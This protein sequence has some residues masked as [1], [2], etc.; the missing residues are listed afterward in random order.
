M[1]IAALV[2]GIIGLIISFI[3]LCGVIAFLPCLVGLAL[4]IADIAIKGKRG[5]PKTM[6]IVGTVLN[7]VALVI[8]IVWSVFIAAGTAE[9]ISDPAFQQ[10]VQKEIEDA[11]KKAQ[12]GQGE[13]VVETGKVQVK[14]TI[15]APP[16]TPQK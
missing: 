2:L 6:G 7:G 14:T 11:Q 13:I 16:K 4:G 1:G 5:Q 10:T 8:I 3:P 12:E 9:A 15:P